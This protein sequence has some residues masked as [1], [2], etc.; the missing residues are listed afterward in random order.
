MLVDVGM[1]TFRN[2]INLAKL[3]TKPFQEDGIRFM[4]EREFDPKPYR[5][6][7]GGLIAYD[8]GLGKTIMTIGLLL[9]H[10]VSHTLIVVPNAIIEQ[11]ET[12]VMRL[13]GHVPFVYHG[14]EKSRRKLSECPIVITTYGTM[15]ANK[16]INELSAFKWSR[17]IYDE[18]HRLRNRK[19][20]IHKTAIQMKTTYTWCLTGTPVQNK[21]LDVLSICRVLKIKEADHMTEYDLEWFSDKYVIKRTKKGVG[22]KLKDVI[23]ENIMVP[24]STDEECNMARDM[25][26]LVGFTD[27]TLNNVNYLMDQLI[28]EYLGALTR[29]RQMC[30]YPALM[31]H[32]IQDM[33][34]AEIVTEED[35]DI[36]IH[37]TS[38]MT[39]VL[40]KVFENQHNGCKK[41]IFT[42]FRLESAYLNMKLTEAG[43]KVGVLDGSTPMRMREEI[44]TATDYDVLLLQIKTA[45]EGINLQQYT[46]IYFT[47]P[48]WNPSVEDQAVGRSHR[49]GQKEQVKVYR[50]I[51]EG[52]GY[53]TK[54]MEEYMML[55]QDKKREWMKLFGEM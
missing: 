35:V 6:C 43:M 24:W 17:V 13:L 46:E 23:S 38:K 2:W 20:S 39:T 14:T 18:A 49:I 45:S 27:V 50:F 26:S 21:L 36:G 28:Q 42:H 40:D 12:E 25:H 48:H 51:M 5:N 30:V 53:G 22:I 1:E 37:G 7:R 31:M 54:S 32:I 33:I 29:M 44:L 10:K 34:K 55:I 16:G 47:A 3:D 52:F 41:I 19:T 15:S 4:L 9:S 8:M 11:W